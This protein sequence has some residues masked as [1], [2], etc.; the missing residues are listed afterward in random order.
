M[1]PAMQTA[2]PNML[3]SW[4]VVLTSALFFFYIFIQMNLFN[5]INSELVKEFHFNAKQLGQLFAFFSYGNVLFVFPAG[6]LLDRFSVRKILLIVFS[7]SVIA[8]YV[9]STASDL[10]V[11]NAARL[12][13]GLAGAFTLLSAIKLASRWFDPCHMALVVGVVVTMAMFGGTIAQ[14]PLTLLIQKFGWRHSMQLVAALGVILIALQLIIVR[15]EPK[16]LEKLDIKEHKQLE[17]LG[18]WHSLAITLT[19]KQ[20][21]LSGIYISLVNLPLFVFGGIWGVPY[22]THV[23]NFTKLEATEITSM[24]FIGMM[25]GSPLAGWI[26]DYLGRR[27]LPMIIG[28]MFAIL[29][30]SA[31]M[32]APTL[33]FA[34]EICLYF[35]LGLIMGFQVIGYPVIAES[36]PHTITATA[37]GFGSMLIMSGGMLVPLFGWLLEHSGNAQVIDNITTYTLADFTLAN[38]MML[39]GLIIALLASF[40]IKETCTCKRPIKN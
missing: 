35:A 24:L 34:A 17:R 19:N 6:M 5:S 38:Y 40:L 32:F 15:D 9:F 30:M 29:A 4:I 21:W 25:I 13:I 11:M 1:T 18:F 12:A 23:H 26:S 10:W 33:H 28:A 20:N 14:T 27:K 16:G 2:Q 37:T 36:N 39:V 7:I 3:R 8:T 22:L 31:I